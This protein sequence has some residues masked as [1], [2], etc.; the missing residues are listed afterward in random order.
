MLRNITECKNVLKISF[1]CGRNVRLKGGVKMWCSC[2]WPRQRSQ[3]RLV[4]TV[5]VLSQQ[6]HGAKTRSQAGRHK[7]WFHLLLASAPLPTSADMSGE[8]VEALIASPPVSASLFPQSWDFKHFLY[9]CFLGG[10][11]SFPLSWRSFGMTWE[12][13]QQLTELQSDASRCL[14]RYRQIKAQRWDDVLNKRLLF[15]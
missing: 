8:T 2:V 4:K 15:L 5:H 7:R 10:L 14:S 3:L 13:M 11:F 1:T 12:Q 6:T 9:H